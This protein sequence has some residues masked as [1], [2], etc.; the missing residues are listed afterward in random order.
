LSV[1]PAVEKLIE[2][3]RDVNRRAGPAAAAAGLAQADN[4]ALTLLRAGLKRA[5]D[6]LPGAQAD[7]EKV[8]AGPD[9]TSPRALAL[10]GLKS[11]LRQRLAA[12]EK[13]FYSHLFRT[14][15]SEW[16]NE[17][18]LALG[19]EILADPEAPAEAGEYARSQEPILA[20][21]LGRYDRAVEL[22]SNPRT[23][24][25][26]KWLAEAELRRGRFA[27]GAALRLGEPARPG[28]PALPPDPQAAFTILTQGG[29]YREASALAEKY[30][31]LKKGPDYAWRL[32]LAALATQ[33]FAAARALFEPLTTAAGGRRQAGAGYFL[34][35]ALAGAGL[36]A[37]AE[38]AY[39]RVVQGPFSYY[40][41][42]AEGRLAQAGPTDPP[43]ALWA[44][45][46]TA[47]PS[48]L[49]R[50][51]LGFHLWITEKS[52]S[53]DGL[54]RAAADL[55][56]AGVIPAGGQAIVALNEDL[57]QKLSRRD[58]AGLLTLLRANPAAFRALTPAARNLWPP[59]AAAVAARLGDYR[60]AVSLMT[61]IKSGAG[62]LK[63]WAH[64]LVYGRPVLE[65][66]RRHSLSP[67]LL[68]ALIRTE[69][70]YQADIIS[71]SNARGLMQLLPATANRV[72]RALNEA[73][74]GAVALFDPALNIRYGSWY[75]AALRDGFGH[76]A[77]A[78]AG[79]NG[80]PHNIK[81]L[82]LARPGLPLDIFI[83]SLFKD[84]TVNYVKRII[85]SRYIYEITYLG[86]ATRP[87]LTGSVRPPRVTLPDF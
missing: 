5:A 86:R 18:A 21:R 85:E 49:D 68:L 7:Y 14:L 74:P 6:D 59:L 73:E 41:I 20:L 35:R 34:G 83:E 1:D 29:L 44:P 56:R 3:A 43:D 71:A 23:A 58:W 11:V 48:G 76:E 87:D 27:R 25:Q 9:R 72:A 2:A 13:A 60:L 54:E 17:E 31:S 4:P 69:S 19:A 39:T 30:P 32:G 10:A 22:W 55:A 45:L 81:S 24:S 77:L 82:I 26:L 40:R 57:V 42:L 52:W 8:L 61:S 84:E 53:G 16:L 33:D 47:G 38:A 37:E 46:L 51:S 12:G 65:A 50:D 15:K 75:L 70:A 28:G 67:A 64:P 66:W 36:I 62:G 79:Y 80:G 78:L 63:K